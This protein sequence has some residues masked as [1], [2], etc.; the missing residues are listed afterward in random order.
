[1][2]K[3]KVK[4]CKHDWRCIDQNVWGVWITKKCKLCGYEKIRTLKDKGEPRKYHLTTEEFYM[5]IAF[6]ALADSRVQV[7]TV[8]SWNDPAGRIARELGITLYK[9][10]EATM[11]YTVIFIPTGNINYRPRQKCGKIKESHD[12]R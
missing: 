2:T 3:R 8:W 10:K 4:R 11:E 7:S 1:M 9:N 5:W 12:E 6:K